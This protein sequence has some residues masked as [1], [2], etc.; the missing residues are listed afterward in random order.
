MDLVAVAVPVALMVLA[1]LV[2]ALLVLWA[3]MALWDR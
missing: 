2:L 3:L 1:L